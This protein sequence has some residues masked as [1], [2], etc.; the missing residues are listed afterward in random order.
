MKVSDCLL[1]LLCGA[2]AALVVGLIGFIRENKKLK[3]ISLVLGIASGLISQFGIFGSESSDGMYTVLV[4]GRP[5]ASGTVSFFW[6]I[7]CGFMFGIVPYFLAGFLGSIPSYIKKHANGRYPIVLRI[8][9]VFFGIPGLF[10]FIGLAKD[11]MTTR[12][13]EP[14][15]RRTLLIV[16][17]IFLAISLLLAYMWWVWEKYSRTK[18]ARRLTTF[19][20]EKDLQ[21]LAEAVEILSEDEEFNTSLLDDIIN[22]PNTVYDEQQWKEIV[23]VCKSFADKKPQECGVLSKLRDI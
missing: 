18:K 22:Q 21:S 15:D 1:I 4:N 3:T 7:A 13:I 12:E 23:K 14:S 6:A 20:D 11:L 10:G 2:I 8:L 16:S 9:C 5:V 17:S 19:L